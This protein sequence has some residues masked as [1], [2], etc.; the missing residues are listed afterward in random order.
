M[1]GGATGE[2]RVGSSCLRSLNTGPEEVGIGQW[3]SLVRDVGG[4]GGGEGGCSSEGCCCRVLRANMASAT[5]VSW[6]ETGNLREF[7]FCSVP[8]APTKT[9]VVLFVGFHSFPN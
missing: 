7:A 9:G 6:E 8:L 2:K 3:G 4:G 1:G 5:D